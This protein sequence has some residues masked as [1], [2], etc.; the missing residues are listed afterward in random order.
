MDDDEDIILA[1]CF[2]TLAVL[3]ANNSVLFRMLRG[4]NEEEGSVDRRT[5]PRS[6]KIQFDHERAKRCIREDYL[7]PYP[8]FPGNEFREQFKVS[9]RQFEIIA[10]KLCSTNKWF[11]Q[12]TDACGVKGASTEAKIM[13]ALKAI[14]YGKT[15]N[16]ERDYFQ[17]SKSLARDSL[18]HFGRAIREVFEEEYLRF[19]SSTDL[20]RI[21][22]LHEYKHKVKGMLG[23][24]DCSQIK[25][26]NCPKANHG[27]Y[28]GK[29]EEPTIA[30]ESISDYNTYI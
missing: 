16:A 21:L 24:L 23:C 10:Q 25:W 6:K 19:P 18:N 11:I 26:K 12:G 20:K 22:R 17:M 9:R 3:I 5:L 30:L 8:R 1:L 13:I 14:A 29:E 15:V 4:D 27:Q 7:S 28:R 2:L